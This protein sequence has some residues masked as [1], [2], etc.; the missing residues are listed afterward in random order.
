MNSSTTSLKRC[1]KTKLLKY[2][3]TA[4]IT[5]FVLIV[6]LHARMFIGQV[7]SASD[8][9]GTYRI[10]GE[11]KREMTLHL[12]RDSHV[13]ID[14]LNEQGQH[15]V[16][17]AEWRGSYA[18]RILG[19]LYKPEGFFYRWVEKNT[20]PVVIYA[21]YTSVAP[22]NSTSFPKAGKQTESII[23]FRSNAIKFEG[24]WLEKVIE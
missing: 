21:K 11:D 20:K 16:A 12:G 17:F 23:Y 15:E 5:I 13:R 10:I 18:T 2:A 8:F 19:P 4:A 22:P 9:I 14:Y 3:E 7:W 24:M 1:S 6:L